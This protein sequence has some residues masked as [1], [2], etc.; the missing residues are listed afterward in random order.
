MKVLVTTAVWGDDYIRMFAECS[1]ASLLA[2][3]NLPRLAKGSEITWQVIAPERDLEYLRQSS[4]AA[5]LRELCAIEEISFESLGLSKIPRGMNL[6][7]YNFLSELQNR[8]IKS[9]LAHDAIVFN[10][11]D[12]VWSDGS[13]SRCID[14]M[15][16]EPI[17]ALMSFCLPV[18]LQAGKRALD[19]YREPDAPHRLVLSP[20]ACAG[21]AI[22]NL[23]REARLRIWDGDE[24]TT[25]PTY[26]LWRAGSEGLVVRSYHLTALA[27]RVKPEDSDYV[28]GIR[29]GTLDGHFS[30]IVAERWPYTIVG[31]SDEALVFSLYHTTLNTELS[32][33][34][35]RDDAIY[36][37]LVHTTHAQRRMANTP[38]L[39][40]RDYRDAELW[41]RVIEQ[42][43]QLVQK[44]ELPAAGLRSPTMA[45]LT[46]SSVRAA[47]A[48]NQ[49]LLQS[50][51][52]TALK[53]ALG[54]RLR[55][56]IGRAMAR[57]LIRAESLLNSGK[58]D[59]E[60]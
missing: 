45:K 47:V 15:Q 28:R 19:S 57:N 20:R 49:S 32:G 4:A 50:S 27:L 9:S 5:P 44:F 21:V 24:F 17:D 11:A 6:G 52:G 39:I 1:A 7:K 43:A 25:A 46:R 55:T 51:L 56:A 12:F 18:D 14:R 38:I 8:A 23:H 48:L 3:G 26:M 42:S 54:T 36:L 41:E 2:P 16:S 34:V 60:V 10:Y 58:S 22:D 30:A 40:K 31:N 37:S 33:P 59:T 35:T 53:A 29:A 13:L